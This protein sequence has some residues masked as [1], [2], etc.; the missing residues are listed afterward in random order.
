MLDLRLQQPGGPLKHLRSPSLPLLPSSTASAHGQELPNAVDPPPCRGLRRRD[1][2]EIHVAGIAIGLV[3]K[4]MAQRSHRASASLGAAIAAAGVYFLAAK[5]S[6]QETL[7]QGRRLRPRKEPCPWWEPLC[8]RDRSSMSLV[9]RRTRRPGARLR[10]D[11]AFSLRPRTT[12]A[13]A[14]PR[15]RRRDAELDALL[16]IE[17][18]ALIRGGLGGVGLS[19]EGLFSPIRMPCPSSSAIP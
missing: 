9:H 4:S 15:S 18:L 7:R 14:A 19:I 8:S 3:V 13:F 16:L 1:R 2:R 5:G 17:T 11:Q 6:S 10:G 12:T